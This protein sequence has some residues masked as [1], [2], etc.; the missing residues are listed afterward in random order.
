MRTIIKN[1]SII[2]AYNEYKADILIEDEKIIGIS[3]NIKEEADKI[4]D[5]S[6]K[7]VFPG[8]G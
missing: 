8:G 3:E 5:A 6:G 1:G 4:I 2:T 7:Y